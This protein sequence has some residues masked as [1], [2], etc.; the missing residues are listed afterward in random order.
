MNLIGELAALATAFFFALTA[1]IFTTTGR[2][3]GSQVTNRMRLLFA[4]LYLIIINLILF[5]EP[6]PFSAGS[7]RWLCLS[8]SEVI[9]LSLGDAFLFQSMVSVGTRIGSL[10]LSLAPIF[11]SIIAWI[12]FGEVLSILQ[13]TGITLALTGIA[14]VVASHQEPPDTPRGHTRRGVIF[15]IF[16]PTIVSN[17]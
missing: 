9:G 6:L 4:L 1:L 10:L 15:G 13:I 11:G 8:L 14:W 12:F 16:K 3:V 7:S 2:S 5:R 17:G